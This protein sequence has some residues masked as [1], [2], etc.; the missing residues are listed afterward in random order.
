MMDSNFAILFDF[1]GVLADTEPLHWQCWNEA[2]RQTGLEVTW[3]DYRRHCVGISDRDFLA[4]LGALAT[5][6]RTVD[7]LLPYYPLKKKLFAERATRGG[8][9]QPELKELLAGLDP[10]R[11]AVVTSSSRQE[12]EP[13][14]RAEGVL[15]RFGAAVYG[16]EVRRLKPDPEPYR[17]AMQRLGATRA[18]AFEDSAAGIESARRAGCEVIEVSEARK[19]PELLRALLNG[20]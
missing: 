10:R 17:T 9:I 6:P 2:L 19:V 3:D 18:V 1:D 14:L 8:L 12:I 15:D 7:E 4:R 5:P 13:I 20:R 16:D 11:L